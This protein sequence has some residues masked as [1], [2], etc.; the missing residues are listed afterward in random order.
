MGRIGLLRGDVEVNFIKLLAPD[1]AIGRI[2]MMAK[3]VAEIIVLLVRHPS[4]QSLRFAR[5]ILQVKPRFTMVANSNLIDLYRL[6]QEANKLGLPGDIVECGVWNGGSAAMMGVASAEGQYA[7]PRVMWLFD[8][9][10]GLPCPTERDGDLE[11][12]SY[13][14]DWNIGDPEKVKQIFGKLGLGLENVRIVPGWFE[15]TLTTVPMQTIAVLH[16]D[17]DWYDSVK[18]VLE[19]LYDKV[20]PG[21]FIILDDYGYW[22]GCT[23]AWHDFLSEHEIENVSIRRN[24]QAGAFLQKPTPPMNLPI[25]SS[26]F[27]TN[28]HGGQEVLCK[29]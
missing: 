14:A 18:T 15:V 2:L 28:V 22:K 27:C 10:Q 4:K 5:I 12:K 7:R 3:A 9:F 26:P 6:V 8:S 16:I 25:R 23:Q 21:G 20:V 11:R 19:V 24:G 13:F 17:A 29:E 1:F